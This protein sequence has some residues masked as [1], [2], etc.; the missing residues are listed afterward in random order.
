MVFETQRLHLN[1][2]QPRST[3]ITGYP[4]ASFFY[5]VAFQRSVHFEVRSRTNQHGEEE[6]GQQEKQEV[7]SEL[8][9]GMQQEEVQ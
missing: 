6:A 5:L 2:A 3:E 7:S 9:R 4:F 1:A 8:E